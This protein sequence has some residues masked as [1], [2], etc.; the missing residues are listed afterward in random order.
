MLNQVLIVGA[1]PTG[2]MAALEL[3]RLG[4]PVRIID[5]QAAPATTSRAVGVQARTLE[6]FE[7]RGLAE[8]M[9]RLGNAGPAASIYAGGKRVLRLDFTRIDSRY[10]Y[11]LFISQA[12]TERI[13]RTAV[14]KRGIR[15]ER[16]V[17]LVGLAQDMLSPDRNPVSVVLRHAD[18]HLEQAQ[19]PWLISAEGAHS[20][21]RATLDIPF[22]GRTREEQYA[23]G[24]VHVEGELAETDAHIFSA[25]QGFMSV[26]P[27]GHRR[28][29][30]I[31]ANPLSHP[32]KDAA[33][34]LEE[35]Q[36]IYDQRSP[37]P[38][39]FQ[40]MSWSSWFRINSRI[41]ARLKFGRLLLGGDAAHIHA[42][43][44]AQGMNTGIQDMINLAWKLALV[45]KGQAPLALLD[46]Y[47]QERLPVIRDVL[48]KTDALTD[49]V[50][51]EKQVGP[52]AQQAEKAQ[53]TMAD[54]IAQLAISYRDSP[55][56]ASYLQD[57]L[58]AGDRVPD[59]PV[60]YHGEGRPGWQERTLFSLLDPSRFSLLVV[61]FAAWAAAPADLYDAVQPWRHII[62]IVE[63][64]PAP[65]A[66][67]ERFQAVFGRSGGVFLVRPDGY[68]GFASGDHESARQL[69]AYCR[70]WLSAPVQVPTHVAKPVKNTFRADD[71]LEIVGEVGGQGAAALVFLHGW[72]GDLQYL[73]AP[74][75][76]LRRRLPHR[77]PRS[78]RARRVRQGPRGVDRRRPG[79]RRR[80]GG[81]GAGP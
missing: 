39:R 76:P 41:V 56:S 14:E 27:M 4:V 13:L 50:L 73:E 28:F 63:L 33:P 34:A 57:A 25:A 43:A 3:S 69:D 24:D 16:G 70:L 52:W 12:E 51:S 38:A 35:L 32:S 67:R 44:G 5:K 6:L 55:L 42:P 36:A 37:I 49:T 29:R 9:V 45:V 1:G 22:E 66:A 78:G 7:Q 19:T 58:R 18:G 74:S 23:L 53:D 20:T 72:C 17:E 11:S 10:H 54:R 61:R 59:L 8:E 81:Q 60:R 71:G 2:L 62:G 68:V 75:R 47:E 46:T 26:F 31:A 15:I 65:G 64:A 21:V 79:R 77:H 80:G 30:V 48:A 40:D